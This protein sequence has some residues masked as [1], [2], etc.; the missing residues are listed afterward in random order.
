VQILDEELN[1]ASAPCPE[2]PL[3]RLDEYLTTDSGRW[4]MAVMDLDFAIQNGFTVT[5]DEVSYREFMLLKLVIM[6]RARW[7]REQ[8]EAE[9]EKARR[10]RQ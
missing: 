6:E 8:Q 1:E 4:I 7:E 3:V 2:C 10:G 9:I 5:L